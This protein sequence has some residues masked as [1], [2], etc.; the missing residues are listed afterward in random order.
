[1]A[2]Y[3]VNSSS[4]IMALTDNPLPLTEDDVAE[5]L[6]DAHAELEDAVFGDPDEP[7][8][9][10]QREAELR[11]SLREFSIPWRDMEFGEC[12]RVGRST[13]IYK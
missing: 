10:E 9:W 4:L 12:L 1:M 6:E 5:P 8:S 7:K 11:D 3:I 13:H 2:S